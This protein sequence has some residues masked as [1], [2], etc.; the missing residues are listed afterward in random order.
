LEFEPEI[1]IENSPD[2][3]GPSIRGLLSHDLDQFLGA[4]QRLF[5]PTNSC[6]EPLNLLPSGLLEREVSR[7]TN[8]F[9]VPFIYNPLTTQFNRGMI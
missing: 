8:S 3:G 9:D 6:N 1:L 2:S 7:T 5:P 4:V